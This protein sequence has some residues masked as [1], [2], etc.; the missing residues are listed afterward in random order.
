M[1]VGN[2]STVPQRW[3]FMVIMVTWHLEIP[4]GSECES[5]FNDTL[6]NIL[7]DVSGVFQTMPFKKSFPFV[8]F[9]VCCI[10][11]ETMSSSHDINAKNMAKNATTHEDFLKIPRWTRGLMPFHFPT[12]QFINIL[13]TLL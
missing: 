5:S 7:R 13:T 12:M 2:S 6:K 3:P 11:S 9:D 8:T 4:I 10:Y 1:C